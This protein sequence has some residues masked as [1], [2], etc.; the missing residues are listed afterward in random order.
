MKKKIAA[1]IIAAVV[2]SAGSLLIARTVYPTNIADTAPDHADEKMRT[3]RYRTDLKTLAAETEKIIPSISTYA[4]NWKLSGTETTENSTVIRAEVPVVVFTDDLQVKAEKDAQSG[5]I[6]VKVHSNS[7]VGK[8][9]FGENRRHVLQIL[10][11]LD[12]RFKN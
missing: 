4:R 9:D 3:R 8:S 2:V 5:A 11:A 10:E 6:I 12:A 7:R 1:G